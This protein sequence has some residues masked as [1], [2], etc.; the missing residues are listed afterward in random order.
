MQAV[1]VVDVHAAGTVFQHKNHTGWR[2]GGGFGYRMEAEGRVFD[3]GVLLHVFQQVQSEFVQPQIHDGDTG[4]HFLDIHHF[5]LKA[6][7]LNLSIFQLGFLLV[8]EK[9]VVAGCGHIHNFHAGFHFCL[10]VDVFV[11]GHIRPK[12]DKLNVRIFAAD[13]V[14]AAKTLDDADGIPVDIVVDEVVAVLQVLAFGDAVGSN[15]KVDAAVVAGHQ[16]TFVF[17]N[18]GKAGENGV[19]VAAQFGD[20]GAAFHAAGDHGGM[21][22]E[23][24]QHIGA[25]IV[26]EI[27]SGIGKGGENNHLA[28]AGIDGMLH[29]FPED[30]QQFLQFAVVFGGDV[31][32]H[33]NEQFQ[34]VTVFDQAVP[35]GQVIHIAN[36]DFDFAAKGEELAFALIVGVKFIHVADVGQ[37]QR[38][39]RGFAVGVDD[40]D[41]AVNQVHNALEGKG[42]GVDRT[43]H[44]LHQIDGGKAADALFAVGLGEANVHLVVLVEFRVL[45]YFAAVNKVRW[46]IDGKGELHQ[47]FKNLIV[48][49]GLFQICKRRTQ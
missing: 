9:V 35:P 31:A 6:A 24:F 34:N 39:C 42:E 48:V 46:G 33:Q 28:I 43:F 23:G 3:V 41:G 36:F 37:F 12:V 38:R 27:F 47:L 13:A 29:L 4:G 25:Y 19:E 30:L 14:D 10:E 44:A 11:Q 1:L 5:F 18:G 21:Y 17:G 26:V 22:P 45:F 16:Q 2:V 40:L 32:Y 20:S 15:Q 7:K 49:D 8:A